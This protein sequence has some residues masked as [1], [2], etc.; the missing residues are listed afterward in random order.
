MKKTD[1]LFD[2][3]AEILAVNQDQLELGE[4][5][6]DN[7]NND[8]DIVEQKLCEESKL[9]TDTERL[10]QENRL[11]SDELS[12]LAGIL[13]LENSIEK[14]KY[15]DI[16]LLNTDSWDA[17]LSSAQNYAN[18]RKL[19][20]N[21][22]YFKVLS[23]REIVEINQQIVRDFKLS[24][25]D[26]MDY[27]FA[28]SV[29]II[30]GLVDKFLIGDITR[31]KN[32]GNDMLRRKVD[33]LYSK[34]VVGY[35]NFVNPDGGKFS[36]EKTAIKFLEGKYAVNYD[37]ATHDSIIESGINKFTPN[38]HHI[39]S[40]AHW[41][42]LLGLIVGI[43]DQITGKTT[44][45]N[46]G[47]I[48]RVTTVNQGLEFSSSNMIVK[49]AESV[50]NWFGHIMSDIAG[51]S[52]SMQRGAGLP[53]PFFG[54]LQSLNFGKIGDKNFGE[55]STWLYEKG[56]DLRMFTA[57][58]IPVILEEVMIRIYMSFKRKFYIDEQ[59]GELAD[60]Y[61]ED[62]SRMLLTTTAVFEAGDVVDALVRS[63]GLNV[64]VLLKLNYVNVADMGFR[65]VQVLRN[66]VKHIHDLEQK[67][68]E[69][70]REWNRISLE[71]TM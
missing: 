33:E 35:A 59:T 6:L 41:P 53:A 67:D 36:S 12:E 61:K 14:K 5:R 44:I 17:L 43:M 55:V 70:Q 19:D 25:L 66:K 29:G 28:A 50:K 21:D 4:V 48:E 52:T 39:K 3:L 13:A 10:L 30:M 34:V 62:L 24:R 1:D 26:G 20:M 22:P 45:F 54:T 58:S 68:A 64:T 23:E 2:D 32:N 63:G 27:A 31:Q 65:A 47:R 8:L 57:Q 7:L 49:I 51:S 56:F 38:N 18:V 69:L 16:Q 60:S 9:F 15:E 40:I 42:D 46:N 11:S 37:A 71:L